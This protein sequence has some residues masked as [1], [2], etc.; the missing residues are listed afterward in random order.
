MAN[1]TLQ[2]FRLRREAFL[3]VKTLRDLAH[4]LKTE[5]RQLSLLGHQPQ[6]RTFTVPKRDGERREIEAP[7]A[8][9]KK[10]QSRLNLFLQAVYYFERTPAAHGFVAATLHELD[11]RNIVT[12]ARKHLGKPHLVNIDLEDFFHSITYNHVVEI[13]LLPPFGFRL[14]LAEALAGVTTFQGRLPVG[15]PTS[16]VLSNDNH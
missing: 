1:V 12:N 11:C 10:L 4:L 15:A 6:Y 2:Q 13:F 9:L 14:P 8:Y 7:V 5:P 3:G 16:P